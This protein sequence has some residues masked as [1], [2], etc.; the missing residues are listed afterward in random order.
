MPDIFHLL[1]IFVPINHASRIWGALEAAD[2]T[3][4]RIV[5]PTTMEPMNRQHEIYGSL[6]PHN[7]F[8]EMIVYVYG[9]AD[10]L[11]TVE[12]AMKTYFTKKKTPYALAAMPY[13]LFSRKGY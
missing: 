10:D 6:E 8:H 7:G 12:Q 2:N 1:A 4:I 5:R 13:E 9:A 11:S 3:G